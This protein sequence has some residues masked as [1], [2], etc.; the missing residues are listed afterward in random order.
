M[1][2][3]MRD[4]AYRLAFHSLYWKNPSESRYK[5]RRQPDDLPIDL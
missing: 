5:A 2:R 4:L 1:L 3:R